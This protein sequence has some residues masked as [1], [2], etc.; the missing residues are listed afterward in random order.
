MIMN[1]QYKGIDIPKRSPHIEIWG[2]IY[3][4]E[5][6][7][8]KKYIGKK[9]FWSEITKPALKTG[10]LRPNSIRLGKR[11]QMTKD[12]LANRTNSQKRNG[13][14][15]KVIPFDV[16]TSE[17]G[18]RKYTGSSKLT[19][20]MTIKRKTIVEMCSDKINLTYCE[21]KWLMRVDALV[22]DV[23]LNDCIGGKF[24][25]GRINKGK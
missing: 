3:I 16:V 25:A 2:F 8:G 1:W 6:T 14:K 18:W 21:Q 10:I 24:Y 11:V 17:N 19:K 15:T 13:V 23:Y 12:D 4:I 22:D 5:Y 7:N 20:G 9:Q